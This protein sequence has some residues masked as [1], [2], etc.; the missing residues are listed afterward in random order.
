MQAAYAVQ[1]SFRE[2]NLQYELQR[3]LHNDQRGGSGEFCGLTSVPVKT[4]GRIQKI[5]WRTAGPSCSRCNLQS[6]PKIW[7]N[8]TS[9][10]KAEPNFYQHKVR[11]IQCQL[12][13]WKMGRW[14]G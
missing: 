6:E 7:E 3:I 5:Q 8:N 11:A 13:K 12:L 9:K 4:H 14:L 10:V 1:N 2:S